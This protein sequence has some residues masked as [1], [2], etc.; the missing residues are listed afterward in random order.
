LHYSIP[1]VLAATLSFKEVDYSKALQSARKVSRN[2]R[3]SFEK[4]AD[5]SLNELFG[6]DESHGFKES[7]L[8]DLDDL[9]TML[10]FDSQ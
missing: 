3:I 6:G 4:H 1:E 5:F 7:D 9:L 2:T 8:G 10:F